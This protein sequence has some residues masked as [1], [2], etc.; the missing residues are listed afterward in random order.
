MCSLFV[1]VFSYFCLSWFYILNL[2][3]LFYSVCNICLQQHAHVS[4]IFIVYT[5]TQRPRFFV[6]DFS[7]SRFHVV[8]FFIFITLFIY[9]YTFI[10]LQKQS[11]Q[12]QHT[13]HKKVSWGDRQKATR[14]LVASGKLIASVNE[15]NKLFAVDHNNVSV[16]ETNAVIQHVGER[17]AED[18]RW[19]YL[20]DDLDESDEGAVQVAMGMQP[21]DRNVHLCS[22]IFKKQVRSSMRCSLF[23]NVLL[24]TAATTICTNTQSSVGQMTIACMSASPFRSR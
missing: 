17:L 10:C 13:N 1:F 23:Y 12:C 18:L 6:L 9:I 22:P 5:Q 19:I 4:Y 21:K 16:G 20:A 14:E 15:L 7:Y 3:C 8:I 2:I 24:Q 11:P